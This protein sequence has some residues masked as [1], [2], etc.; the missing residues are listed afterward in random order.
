MR[1]LDLRGVVAAAAVVFVVGAGACDEVHELDELEP[2]DRCEATGGEWTTLGCSGS[3][4]SCGVI[5][6]NAADGEGCDCPE[7]ECF[8][9]TGCVP[10]EQVE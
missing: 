7:G 5:A 6:C 4:D 3:Q 10:R 2:E 1:A 8:D 9:D